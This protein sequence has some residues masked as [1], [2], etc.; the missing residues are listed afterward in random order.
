MP[1]I[2]TTILVLQL[3]NCGYVSELHFL[4][5]HSQRN[6][7]WFIHSFSVPM[8][9]NKTCITVD[10]HGNFRSLACSI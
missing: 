1:T 9:F 4:W 2:T 7:N 10:T 3:F 8:P 5:K 6:C